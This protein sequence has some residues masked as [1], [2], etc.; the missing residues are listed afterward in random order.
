MS[1]DL[2]RLWDQAVQ[3]GALIVALQLVLIIVVTWIALR[4]ARLTVRAGLAQLF[5]REAAEGTATGLS[6]VEVTRRHRTLDDLLFGVLRVIILAIAF[7]MALQILRLDIGPAI[8]G[9]GIIGLALSLG[10]QSLV[11]D[12]VAGA[13]LL[14]ENHYSEGDVVDIAGVSGV[15]EDINL[16]RTTVRSL[17]GVLHF[18]PHGLVKTS[19]N[20]TRGWAR[21]SF[22]VPVGF[23]VDID[24]IKQVVNDAGQALAADPA[25][26]TRILEV[27]VFVRLGDFGEYGMS[28]TVLGKVAAGAQ[29]DATGEMRRR[30]LE[31]ARQRKVK[32]GWPIDAGDTMAAQTSQTLPSRRRRK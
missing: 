29:W 9:L 28:A 13:F 3:S 11:R 23:D 27:P 7:L 32:I 6:T 2:P 20:M 17:D 31:L 15:V 5:A 14:I 24:A 19:S 10:A 16:R 30:I 26:Q 8:A 25:W 12:Y 18:V 1:V 21:V 4:F 22:D